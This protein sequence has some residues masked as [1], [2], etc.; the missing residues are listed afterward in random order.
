MRAQADQG[1]VLGGDRHTVFGEM[2]PA[3]H[4]RHLLYKAQKEPSKKIRVSSLPF[5]A[6]CPYL[7]FVRAGVCIP[8]QKLSPFCSL[9]NSILF[10][11]LYPLSVTSTALRKLA[12]QGNLHTHTHTPRNLHHTLEISLPL[13]VGGGRAPGDTE[14]PL[15]PASQPGL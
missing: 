10:L 9:E 15:T 8:T 2:L 3:G 7:L 14:E 12:L 4:H 5:K 13:P 1:G 6:I 11:H